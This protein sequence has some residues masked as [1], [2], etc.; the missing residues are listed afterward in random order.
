MQLPDGTCS[1]PLT[2]T[3]HKLSAGPTRRL[4]FTSSEPTS[5]SILDAYGLHMSVAGSNLEGMLGCPPV[6]GVL[7]RK[8][9]PSVLSGPEDGWTAR[10]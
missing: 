6:L 4:H 3:P 7:E 8:L 2:Y 5:Y 10:L 9:L 1:P